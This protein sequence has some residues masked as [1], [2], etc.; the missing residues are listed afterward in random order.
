MSP[1]AKDLIEK[2]LVKDPK[3]RL[4]ADGI[5]KHPFFEGI[6]WNNLRK[7]KAPII[8]KYISK[9]DTS[10]FVR[11]TKVFDDKEKNDPFYNEASLEKDKVPNLNKEKLHHL[12]Q[13]DLARVD[14][15]HQ[16]NQQDAEVYK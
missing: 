2:L 5:K 15:L 8:P 1:E 9:K 6:D 12:E 11:E 10:N 13:F 7:T 14:L 16:L 4:T 3:S